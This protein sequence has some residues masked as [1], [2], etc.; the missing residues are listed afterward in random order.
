MAEFKVQKKKTQSEF[1][2]SFDDERELANSWLNEPI[3]NVP[4]RPLVLVEATDPISKAISEMNQKHTGCALVVREG[5]LVGIF[6]ERDVL[7]KVVGRNFALDGKV[8][9]V[10]TRDPDTLPETA[11]V[12]YALRQMSVEGYRHIPVIDGEHRPVSLVAVRDIL[13]WMCELFPATVMNLPP[14]PQVPRQVDGG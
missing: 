6:T 4:R 5:A 12:A 14:E 9:Q 11:T 13:G 2:E 7:T 3:R 8:E 1:E 10:M